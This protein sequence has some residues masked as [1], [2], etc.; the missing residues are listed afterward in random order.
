MAPS[1]I[2]ERIGSARSMSP[3]RPLKTWEKSVES[4]L[5]AAVLPFTSCVSRSNARMMGA[6]STPRKSCRSC[7]CARIPSACSIA[8][9][10]YP[11][12]SLVSSNVAAV[13]IAASAARPIPA[14]FATYFS[15]LPRFKV[16]S[17][18]SLPPGLADAR[19]ALAAPLAGWAPAPS[20]LPGRAPPAHGERSAI[21]CC[22]MVEPGTAPRPAMPPR[23]P[24]AWVSSARSARAF[25]RASS[26]PS[27]LARATS[28]RFMSSRRARN[29]SRALEIR[30]I[31]YASLPAASARRPSPTSASHCASAS[32]S[33]VYR[34]RRGRSSARMRSAGPTRR[35]GAPSASG[36]APAPPLRRA[37]ALF[38]RRCGSPG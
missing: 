27:I 9:P 18:S 30:A 34:R 37:R 2:D 24:A 32:P 16:G 35:G 15:D 19:R 3:N 17:S 26:R 21:A 12:A 7:N 20:A 1:N 5:P 23:A 10:R 8:M 4:A 11:R 36:S 31:G 29:S 38:P 22:P 6:G 25:S 13:P 33:S 28:P 14:C